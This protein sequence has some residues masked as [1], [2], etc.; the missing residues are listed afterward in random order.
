M[1]RKKKKTTIIIHDIGM[2]S[3]IRLAS[4]AELG[5]PSLYFIALRS[6]Q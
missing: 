1:K 3:A 2:N 6:S 4:N 5:K